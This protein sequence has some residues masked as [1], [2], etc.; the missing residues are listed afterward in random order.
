MA[1][2]E[3]DEGLLEELEKS[4]RRNR[5]ELARRKAVL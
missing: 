1:F 5:I 2:A 3:L 4:I